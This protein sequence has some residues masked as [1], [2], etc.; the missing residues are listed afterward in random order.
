MNDPILLVPFDYETTSN[1]PQSTRGVQLAAMAMELPLYRS[2]EHTPEPVLMMNEITDPEVDIHHEAA[3]VHGITPEMVA[4]KRADH[5]VSKELYDFLEANQHRVILASHN[6]TTFDAPILWRL[7]DM[8]SER[9]RPPLVLPH[10]DCLIL[11]TRIFPHAPNHK[12]SVTQAEYEKNPEKLKGVGLIQHLKLGTGEGAHDALE[13]IRMVWSLISFIQK[14]LKE[15]T[16]SL[17]DLAQWCASPR[18]LKICHFGKH[19]GKPWGKGPG[20][21]PAGYVKFICGLFED[22]TPDM[23]ATVQHHYGMSF[24]FQNPRSKRT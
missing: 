5:V 20:C 17:L 10:I 7:A 15:G 4:G 24:D 14:N 3:E 21:V 11:A 18:V 22:A 2:W 9:P 23:I 12:L 19:K 13:D 16:W 6:G 8:E 1:K